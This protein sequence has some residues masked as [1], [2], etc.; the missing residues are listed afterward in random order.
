MPVVLHSDHARPF[1]EWEGVPVPRRAQHDVHALCAL[2]AL[3]LN[4][5]VSAQLHRLGPAP[6]VAPR[7][8]RARL[9]R[10]VWVLPG[11]RTKVHLGAQ[12]SLALWYAVLHKMFLRQAIGLAVGSWQSAQAADDT[13]TRDSTPTFASIQACK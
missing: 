10:P 13:M 5:A 4:A 3:K 9:M 12:H 11:A 7:P 1:Q 8:D 2:P 6:D